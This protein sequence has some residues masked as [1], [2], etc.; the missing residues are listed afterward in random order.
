MLP[1]IIPSHAELYIKPVELEETSWTVYLN[2]IST[3]VWLVL[4]FVA[5]LI[6][7]VLSGI[8]KLRP[9]INNNYDNIEILA[10]FL[11]HFWIAFKSNFGGK[12]A[13]LHKTT[14]YQGCSAQVD[15]R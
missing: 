2:P 5:I 9:L 10:N 4:T 3:N 6:A 7:I 14:S 8:E 15:K 12:P 13:S 1:A 11:K